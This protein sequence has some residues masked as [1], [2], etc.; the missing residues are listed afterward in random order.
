MPPNELSMA[1]ALVSAIVRG[2]LPSNC[3]TTRSPAALQLRERHHFAHK[4]DAAGL[5][6]VE[7]FAGQR[8]AAHLAHTDGVTSC[9][10]MIAAVS[11]S[12]F[13]DGEQR[14]VGGNHHVAGRDTPVPPPKQPPYQG[15]GRDRRDVEPLH[16]LEV[17]RGC[18][19]VFRHDGATAALIHGD[20]RRPGNGGRCPSARRRAA[21]L[22]AEVID[23]RQHA[24]DQVAVI[25]V[26]DLGAV[27]RDGCD[28]TPIERPQRVNVDIRNYPPDQSR[29]GVGEIL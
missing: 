8:V 28:A 4:T 19:F 5:L 12:A 7:P 16:R 29:F 17:A 2:P 24:L 14:V 22:R 3:P 26:V 13:G 9:G 10:M 21:R 15:H 25:G 1:S 20:Q 18:R 11:P 27:Q 23:R 6:R